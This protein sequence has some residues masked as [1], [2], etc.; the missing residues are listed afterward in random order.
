MAMGKGEYRLWHIYKTG[1]DKSQAF[2]YNNQTGTRLSYAT[3]APR[4]Q[5]TG[6]NHIINFMLCL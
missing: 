3:L 2:W 1:F 4:L 6:L 5:L